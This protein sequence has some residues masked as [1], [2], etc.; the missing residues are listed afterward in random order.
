MPPSRILEMI[1]VKVSQLPKEKPKPQQP[2]K[3]PKK[4]SKKSDIKL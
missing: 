1:K 4:E 3:P 2:I